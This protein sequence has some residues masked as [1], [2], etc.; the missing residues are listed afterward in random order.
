MERRWRLGSA[1]SRPITSSTRMKRAFAR[2]RRPA[3]SRCYCRARFIS[4]ARRSGRRSTCCAG[5]ACRLRWRPIATRA[6]SPLT[7]LLLTMNMGATLFGLTVDECIAGVTREAARALGRLS[8]VG[9]IEAGKS[10]DL[11][12]WDIDRP[13]ELVYRMGFNPL[14]ARV[15]RGTMTPVLLRPGAVS[16]AEWQA[17]YR[18]AGVTLDPGCRSRDQAQRRGG[19]SDRG[20]GRAGLRRQHRVRQT[21]ER[22]DRDGRPRDLAAQPRAYRTRRA[23]AK[24]RRRRW[25]G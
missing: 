9:T 10:C 7:S 18:G 15:W 21:G 25:C 20:E 1:L 3:S 12:I 6:R 22:A 19:R 17:V 5:I 13:A 14:H 23:W 2:W 16:L 24:R 8:D 4:C 11:A